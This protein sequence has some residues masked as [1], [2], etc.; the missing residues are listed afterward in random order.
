MY[1]IWIQ[2]TNAFKRYRPE[3]IFR[4]Y[5]TGR[6]YGR[7]NKGD[8][9]CPPPPI[10]N[11]GGIKNTQKQCISPFSK[12]EHNIKLLLTYSEFTV[13]MQNQLKF[14]NE[15]SQLFSIWKIC[16][17]TPKWRKSV[18]KSLIK[19]IKSQNINRNQSV[20]A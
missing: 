10:I 18:F 6:T 3:T 1:E 13:H 19:G 7:T 15:N 12:A 20:Y 5:G 16:R 9:I 8:A 4:T 14:R 2:Y 17:L 11:G